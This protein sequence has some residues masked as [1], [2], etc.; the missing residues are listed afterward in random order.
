MYLSLSNLKKNHLI[1]INQLKQNEIELEDNIMKK[2]KNSKIAIKKIS[3]KELRKNKLDRNFKYNLPEINKESIKTIQKKKD[4]I[5]E[6]ILKAALKSTY[7]SKN[8]ENLNLQ[9]KNYE[10]KITETSEISC[11]KDKNLGTSI[12]FVTFNNE[13]SK[14]I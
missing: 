10:L 9:I 13:I 2:K 3:L 1:K 11:Q 4:R 6:N 8:L 12:V 14:I 5:S 7:F